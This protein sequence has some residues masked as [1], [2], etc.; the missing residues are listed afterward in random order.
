MVT[1]INSLNSTLAGLNP[2]GISAT[3]LYGRVSKSLL[4]QNASLQKLGATL[5]RDQTRLSGLGQ[6][7][8][9]LA[10]F[11]ALTKSLSGAGLQTAATASNPS[12]LTALTNSAAKTGTFA[13]NVTQLARAQLLSAKAQASKDTAIGSG[14]TTTIKVELGT[15]SGNS[16]AAGGTVKTITIDS[17]NNSLQGIAKAFKDAGL[18]ANVVK[19]SKGFTLQLGGQSGKG[20]SLRISVG[21]DA[22]LQNLLTYNPAGAKALAETASAQDAELTVDGKAFTSASNVVTGA[23]AGTALALT[24]KGA[25]NVVVAQ[26][27]TAIAKNVGNFV[28]GFNSLGERLQALKKDAL[29]ADPAIAQVQDQLT[30]LFKRNEADLGNAGITLGANG[31]LQIDSNKLN[32]AIAANADAVAKLFTDNGNGIADQLGA[33]IGQ[34]IGSNGSISKQKVAV[35]RDI[36]TVSGQK[37]ALTKQLEAQAQS[38]VA[39]YAQVS[40]GGSTNTA[41]PG[42]PGGGATSLFDF[43]A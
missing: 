1:S 4:A 3:D 19:G 20:N 32:G 38:L 22:A 21:G 31:K 26:D 27:S 8:S 42:L 15:E 34:L 9:A 29:K 25:T 37:T 23:I 24:A 39:Q 41:L 18:E 13:V 30:Q 6:L 33:R 11:Q 35:D 10:N 2:N 17:S 5:T 16:F 7:Q 14:A 28:S 43:L 12:I 36:S 40:Q